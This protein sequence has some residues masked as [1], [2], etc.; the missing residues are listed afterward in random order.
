MTRGWR[1]GGGDLFMNGK[2]KGG[3]KIE[4]KIVSEARI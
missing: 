2:F 1:N 4:T 3:I